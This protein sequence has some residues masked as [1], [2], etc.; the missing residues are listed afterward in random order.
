M[1]TDRRKE[2]KR[3]LREISRDP[4]APGA[5]EEAQRL[6]GEYRRL[7]RPERAPV[8]ERSEAPLK[9]LSEADQAAVDTW[10]PELRARL[11]GASLGRVILPWRD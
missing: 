8:A 10:P 9:G 2:I 5:A 11:N 4:G 1:T 3:R 7:S 6:T